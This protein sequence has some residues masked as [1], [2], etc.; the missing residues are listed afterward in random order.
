[1][2]RWMWKERQAALLDGRGRRGFEKEILLEEKY[3]NELRTA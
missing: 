1:M 2:L 3:K